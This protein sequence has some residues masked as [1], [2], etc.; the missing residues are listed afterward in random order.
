MGQS[1]VC[2]IFLAVITQC[3][4]AECPACQ[5][6]APSPI[7]RWKVLRY[8]G[9]D[10]LFNNAIRRAVVDGLEFDFSEQVFTMRVKKKDLCELKF[11]TRKGASFAEIDV[12]DGDLVNKG[13][14][15][16]EDG[17]LHICF[18]ELS[19]QER[20]KEFSIGSDE[21]RQ[22]TYVLEYVLERSK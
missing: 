4:T 13:I 17:R 8:E 22:S 10:G 14:F 7:G 16:M 9:H 2:L 15:K 19:D 1:T 3:L 18:P 12:L 6:K 11:K 5:E 21:K 20:P